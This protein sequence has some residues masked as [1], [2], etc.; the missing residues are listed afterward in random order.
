MF[1]AGAALCASAV[2]AETL[3]VNGLEP[4][5]KDAAAALG[6]IA[7]EPFGGS[8]GQQLAIAVADRLRAVTI[9]G[10]PYFRILPTV[11]PA[12][13]DAV[14]DGTAAAEVGRRDSGSREEQVCVERDEDDKCIRR[15][16][17][18]IPCW[19]HVVRLDAAVRLIA[20]DGAMLHAADRQDELIQRYCQG[21]GRPS[22]EGMV[23]ELAGRYADA[24]RADLAPFQRFDQIRV[25]ESRKGLSKQDSRAF[26]EA[27]RLTKSDGVAACAAWMDI[28]P[29]NPAHASVLFNLGLCAESAGR[30]DEAYDYYRRILAADDDVDYARQGARRIERYRRAEAQLASHRRL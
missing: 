19:D 10:E 8:D 20:I 2:T 24:L 18:H 16:T 4:A 3:P 21:D 14:L 5:G 11:S 26:R 15:E 28:A 17:R 25:M 6:V 30:R 12:E 13:A 29:R 22:S 9:D 1:A 23:R 7:L 27:I